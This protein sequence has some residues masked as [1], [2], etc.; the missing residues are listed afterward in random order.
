MV[1]LFG[2]ASDMMPLSAALGFI[3]CAATL[4]IALYLIINSWRRLSALKKQQ[5][6]EVNERE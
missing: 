1:A 4:F 2:N 5:K 3:V 6:G